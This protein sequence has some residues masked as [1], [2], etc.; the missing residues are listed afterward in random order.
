MPDYTE[1]GDNINVNQRS[2]KLKFSDFT[3]VLEGKD[4]GELG[5]SG[6]TLQLVSHA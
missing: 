5:S 6:K 4:L 3:S 2:T 1:E